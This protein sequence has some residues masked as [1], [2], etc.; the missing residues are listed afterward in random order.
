L[1]G[2]LFSANWLSLNSCG[3]GG[4]GNFVNPPS[5]VGIAYILIGGQGT[6]GTITLL[7]SSTTV[8]TRYV[9]RTDNLTLTAFDANG[10][11]LDIATG[12]QTPLSNINACGLNDS[13]GTLTVSSTA[14]PIASV[15]M[16]DSGNFFGID[17]F[18]FACTNNNNVCVLVRVDPNTGCQEDDGSRFSPTFWND[19]ST[20]QLNNNCYAYATDMDPGH[21]P[22][23]GVGAGLPVLTAANTTCPTVTAAAIADGLVKASCDASCSNGRKV[24]LVVDPNNDYHWYREDSNGTWSHKPGEGKATNLDFSKPP[25][26]ITD[27]RTANRDESPAANYTNFCDCF[28]TPASCN[29]TIKG[30]RANK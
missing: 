17:D 6:V 1:D 25:Q 30:L 21:F 8:S 7:S 28:C 11:V 24:A 26:V 19:N 9:D 16:H 12:P 20:V 10:N 2:A 15:S 23:P 27:P 14:A 4:S 22:Q 29:E 3:A 5:G 18:S 13:W